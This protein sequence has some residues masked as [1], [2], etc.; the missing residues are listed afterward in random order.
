V[1]LHLYRSRP[2]EVEAV[3]WDGTVSGYFDVVS[4]FA[5]FK[6]RLNGGELELLAGK[7]GARGWVPVPVGHWIV[8]PPGDESDIWPVEHEYFTAKYERVLETPPRP[9]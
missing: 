5:R 4:N 3:R 2:Q 6:T 1:N 7:G 8:H 9:T